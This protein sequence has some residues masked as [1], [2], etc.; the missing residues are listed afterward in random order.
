M[1]TQTEVDVNALQKIGYGVYVVCSRDGDKLNGQ[2]AN[3]VFQVCSEPPMVAVAI[4]HKN[5]THDFIQKSGVFSA[6]V[7]SQDTPMPFVGQF[8]FKSGRDVDKFKG[9]TYRTGETGAPIILDNALA[10]LEA[11]VVS[12]VDVGTHMLFVGEVVSA[13]VL[14]EG[15]PM[16]YA[17][18]HFVKRGTAPPTAPTYAGPPRRQEVKPAMSKYECSVCGYIYDPAVGDPDGNIP[19]GTAFESLPETWVCPTCGAPKSD[20]KKVA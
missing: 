7:L 19:P 14:K 5:L 13:G 6:S 4:N 9:V 15:E 18:Y 12:S 20:F 2:I 8:G 3:T 10:Y 16:T 11:K 17:H 1:T